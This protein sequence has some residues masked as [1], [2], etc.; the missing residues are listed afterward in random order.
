MIPAS[1]IA[2]LASLGVSPDQANVI[3]EMLAEVE[4]ATEAKASGAIEYRRANDRERK[5]RQRLLVKSREV[6]G[7]NVKSRDDTGTDGTSAPV[8]SPEKEVPPTPPLEKQTP[9]RTSLRS[10]SG[11]AGA[12]AF[13]RFWRAWPNKVGKPA[14][15]RVFA[16]VADEIEEIM[17]GMASYIRDRPPDRPWLNPATFLN[18]RRWED[19]PAKTS[20]G[21]HFSQPNP[22]KSVHAAAERLHQAALAGELAFP[23]PPT[24]ADV[25]A[26]ARGDER[27][28]DRRLLSQG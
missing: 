7:A 21:F 4:A 24:V 9:S 12:S 14:A 10:V 20:N 19:A 11:S 22:E 2:K 18:Q 17:I 13:D 15:Q 27:E 1:T 5:E 16:K 26:F 28:D 25:L 3:A 23:P 8:P 6:A